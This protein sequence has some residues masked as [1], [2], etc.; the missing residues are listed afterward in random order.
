M[1]LVPSPAVLR[2]LSPSFA[3]VLLLAVTPQA[4]SDGILGF[5]AENAERQREIERRLDGLIDASEQEA[6]NRRMSSAPNHVGAP[7]NRENA[8][9]MAR[10]FRS[11]GYEVEIEVF[12]VLYPTPITRVVELV[13]PTHFVARLTEPVLE[14][15]ATS[16]IVDGR[17]PPY[18]AY[19]SDGDVTA[20]L[21]YVNYGIPADYEELER[22]G[23]S[24]EGKIVI[25][26]YGGSWRGIKPKVATE[27]GAVGCI[28]Y[29]DP[30]DDGYWQG[31]VYPAGPYRM[32][33]G[34]QRGSVSDMP[35]YPGDP[36]TPGRGATEDAERLA[37]EDSPTIMKIPV[38][39]LSYADALPL[40]QAIGGQ[41]APSGWRGALPITYHIGPGPATVHLKLE[42]DWS[43]R[44]AYDVIA[45]L[46]GSEFPDQWVIR[47]NHHDAW[48]FGAADPLSG[49]VSLLSEAK[50]VGELA[51]AGYRPRRTIIYAAWDAEEPG[52]LG[53][54]EWAEHHAEELREKTVVYMNTDGNSRGFLN[55]G[56][57]HSLERMVNEVARDVIDPQ[58]GV[59]VWER[60]RAR[61]AVRGNLDPDHDGDMP[62]YPLGSGSDYTPFLQHL[63]IASLN[64]SY[65]GE[66]GGGSYHSIYDSFDHFSRFRDPGF[67][68]G[69]TLSRTTGRLTL[70]FAN[71]DVLPF[72]FTNLANHVKD[73][74]KEVMEL[75]DSMREATDR[76]NEM[77]M[78][79]Q[80]ELA[81]D[82]TK[83]YTPPQEKEPVPH[84]NFA[85]LQ[86]AV[87]RLAEAAERFDDRTAE[88]LNALVMERDE[89]RQLNAL[90][91]QS[92]RLL[93]DDAGLPRRSWYTHMIYAPGFYTGYGVK[94]LPGVREGIEQRA[95]VEVDEM[96][97]RVAGAVG[98]LAERLERD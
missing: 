21:V 58:R 9:W 10:L 97:E 60:R 87:D 40:M 25:A 29:S 71:A 72:R 83:P 22:R 55:V 63:G 51:R 15:D 48:V 65:G 18:N 44:P 12:H 6:W 27:H 64:V 79:N 86:N 93:A 8:E 78:G 46:E 80:Y 77:V 96:V 24:V 53:S 70:R 1:R 34:A 13:E 82:P 66:G 39:P 14:E 37:I 30:R 16:G 41:V 11:W 36:L 57:S 47:G 31:D 4:N 49:M 45:R 98:R 32:E 52:L 50:A 59:S 38:L 7:H 43:L 68:Y 5:T 94:T 56:G 76:L 90:L 33:Y 92:E 17:L 85:P 73:Y 28:L 88:R 75:A 35:T 26:R 84:I 2:R 89:M 42:F 23:I 81:A 20:Q 62:I 54:T 95:W 3:V 69:A 74:L 67:A 91:I 61:E 19:S